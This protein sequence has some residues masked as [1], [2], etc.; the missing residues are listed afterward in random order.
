MALKAHT[1]AA[2]EQ[3]RDG[4]HPARQAQLALWSAA[5]EGDVHAASLVT[6]I[7]MTRCLLLGL[8]GPGGVGVDALQPRVLVKP[9]VTYR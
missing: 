1:V 7:I 2:V 9:P 8:E 6:R 3:L 5:M 4:G